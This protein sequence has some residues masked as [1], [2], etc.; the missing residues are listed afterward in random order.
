MPLTTK[1]TASKAL[2]LFRCVVTQESID[3]LD[4]ALFS[5]PPV[6]SVGRPAFTAIRAT[7]LSGYECPDTLSEE[8]GAVRCFVIDGLY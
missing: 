6:V 5:P 4:G 2:P 7:I 8:A 1:L 3:V